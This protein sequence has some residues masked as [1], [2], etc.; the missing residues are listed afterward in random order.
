MVLGF[1]CLFGLAL[2]SSTITFVFTLLITS[3]LS[4]IREKKREMKFIE[5]TEIRFNINHFGN[6]FGKVF[7]KGAEL[8]KLAYFRAKQVDADL[9]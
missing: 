2:L 1:Q 4:V 7:L 9:S 5:N 3:N 6:K 8:E